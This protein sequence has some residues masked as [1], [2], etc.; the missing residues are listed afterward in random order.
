MYDASLSGTAR[1]TCKNCI[2]KCVL[3]VLDLYAKI[4]TPICLKCSEGYYYSEGDCKLV[5]SST[6]C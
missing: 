5:S 1:F 2:D 6:L 4:P 3:C